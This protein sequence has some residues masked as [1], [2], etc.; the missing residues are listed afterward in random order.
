MIAASPDG[1]WA[2][3]DFGAKGNAYLRRLELSGGGAQRRLIDTFQLEPRLA[4]D[5]H[6][7]VVV[8]VNGR[9]VTL[10]VGDRDPIVFDLPEEIPP[11]KHVGFCA[12]DATTVLEDA[13]VKLFP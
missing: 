3:L 6:P 10:T 1:D 12:K 9:Y 5:E 2:V 8:H 4:D 7:E 11:A 13:E